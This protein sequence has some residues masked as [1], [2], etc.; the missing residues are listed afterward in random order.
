MR[1]FTFWL[2]ALML[3]F[4]INLATAQTKVISG[5]VTDASG[6]LPG[7]SVVIKGTTKGTQTDFD[8]KYSL[9]ANVGDVLQFTF[10]GME[11]AS[12]TVGAANVIDLKMS[13]GAL[14]LEEVVVVGYGTQKKREVTGSI[15]QVKGNSIA[16]LATPSFESQLAGRAAGVQI[17][18][19]T[20]VLGEAP[21]IRIRGIG[22]ISMGTYPLIV[23]DGMPIFTGNMGG[24]ASANS[25]GD[26]NPSDI[27]SMEILKDGSATAIYGSRA[28]NGVVL[29]TTKKGKGGRFTVNYSNYVGVAS[30]VELYDLLET[31]D[32]I[33]ISNE[34]RTNV[35][36][37][38][39]AIGTEYNTDWQKAVTRSNAFQQDHNLS[40]TGSTEKANYYFSLGYSTQEGVSKP[41]E[42]SRYSIRANVDQKVKDWLTVGTNIAVTKTDYYGMN[43]G[44]NSLSGNIFNAIRQH[45]NVPIYNPDHPTGYNIDLVDARVVGR[46]QNTTLAESN[47][48]N[49]VYVI[50]N[51]VQT[52]N[53]NRTLANIFADV[54]ILPSLKYKAQASVDQ[55]LTEGFYFWNSVHGDGAGSGG[56]IRNNFLNA[57]RWNWQN[58]LSYNNTFAEDHN[59]SMVLVNEFQSQKIK[60]FFGGGNGLSNDFFNE[61][62]ITGSVAT[63]IAGGSMSE[64]AFVSYASRLNYNYK[65]KYFLQGSI[66]YDGISD[67]PEANKW[68]LFPGASIGWTV[69][70]ESFME[71]LKDVVS[72]FKL[73]AS[74]ASVGNVS[75]GNT[76]YLGLFS[77]FKYGD[78][79]GIAF[80]QM[81]N[82][83]LKWETS[84][85]YDVGFDASFVNGK[86]KI[87]FDYFLNDQDGLIMNVPTPPSLGV[88]NNQLAMNIGRVVNH[89]YEFTFDLTLVN[90]D[91]FNWNLDGNL[92]LVGNEVKQLVDG[93]DILS[94][95]GYNMLREGEEMHKLWGYKYWGVNMANGNP[96]Y[97]KADGSL[98]QG[99]IATGAYR[100]YD[101]ANPADISQ[102]SS[103]VSADK[104]FLGTVLP[105]YFG[106]VTSKMSYKDFDLGFMFRFSGGN[107]IHNTTR[108][109][110]L[111]QGFTNNGVEILG[112][113][114]SVANP[115]DGWTPR[116]DNKNDAF[117]NLTSAPSS[118]FV[119]KGDYIKLDNVS[120]GYTLPKSLLDRA[121]IDKMRVFV[122][123]QNLF[124]H[125][126]YTGLDPENES[127]G[128]DWNVN[129]RQRVITMGINMSL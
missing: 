110:L 27:E 53:V 73:R 116:L 111:N 37:Q 65:G 92:S 112:R 128:V 11:T 106:S 126:D 95:D 43:T 86:Y 31:P 12:R 3:V 91:K 129:P 85:K 60:S 87:G 123:G 8:G 54:T 115:G 96:V 67:L 100:V 46:W 47:I 78:V 26:I 71:S 76:P 75:L 15:S 44:Q 103:L 21:R 51:N 49:I 79:N 25:L 101:P 118:R 32:F 57:K 117:I 119:E 55:G 40:M 114:Q 70:E 17:N 82:D 16:S 97:Y 63:Q 125:T 39:W 62:V 108:R 29:I 38:P 124:M 58:I 36:E 122:Q 93:Q 107:Y 59:I 33:T 94:S 28:A 102:A 22:S 120:L 89:G 14:A 48:T 77:N 19:Q 88:P 41:N 104:T 10:V 2:S 4:G 42:M 18:Q 109:N 68:G 69:S 90:N 81:G 1:K 50:D 24:Y 72:D 105:T 34:K 66:R 35:G 121:G 127:L 5:K 6:P 64:T 113:W 13:E 61:N 45:P 52:S 20:G 83:K 84:K 30:P 80:S 7:V 99:N 56:V 98:V 23:V 74:Y 9:T